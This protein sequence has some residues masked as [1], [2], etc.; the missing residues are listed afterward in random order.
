MFEKMH[1][2]SPVVDDGMEPQFWSFL[3]GGE[4][5][6]LLKPVF[7]AGNCRTVSIAHRTSVQLRDSPNEIS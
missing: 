4:V 5:I 1:L 3:L 2:K 7:S 6:L